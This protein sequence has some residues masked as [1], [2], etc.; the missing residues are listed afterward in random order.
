LSKTAAKASFNLLSEPWI[1]VVDLDGRPD[2]LALLD[3][4][5]NAKDFGGIAHED[6]LVVI[7]TYR[8][9]L[10]FLHRALDG[11]AETKET[12]DWFKNGFPAERIENYSSEWNSRFNLFDE[13]HP[14]GQH[15]RL[16]KEKWTDHWSRLMAAR[17]S[18]NTN[19]LYSYELRDRE[20]NVDVTSPQEALLQMLAHQHFALGGLTKRFITS[21]KSS[22]FA[23][24][25]LTLVM[26]KNLLETLCL[27]LIPY[28]ER[29]NQEQPHWEAGPAEIAA[30][31]RGAVKPV[32]GLTESY[33][34]AARSILFQPDESGGIA[35]M[36]YAE[37]L[38]PG[39]STYDDPMICLTLNRKGELY[40]LG[41]REERGLWRDLHSFVPGEGSTAPKVIAEAASVLRR[42]RRY[43]Q[44][45]D[46]ASFGI[47][48]NKAKI[49]QV[50]QE[51][52]RLPSLALDT[53]DLKTTLQ[54]WTQQAQEEAYQLAQALKVVA[55]GLLS[56][57][58]NGAAARDVKAQAAS[59]QA[60]SLYWPQAESLFWAHIDSL[61][62]AA[63]EYYQKAEEIEQAWQDH[64]KRL[65]VQVFNEVTNSLEPTPETLRAINKGY[66]ALW[67]GNS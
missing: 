23:T 4:I 22:P 17:G 39:D 5:R 12:V 26:G 46:F 48:N 44:P 20:D 3:L 36:T 59:F 14:F 58:R 28:G 32:Q 63:E 18:F 16:P 64:L 11:P 37:G 31:E 62:S 30:L 13:S 50:R 45:L 24:A 7:A 21:A 25:C 27:N 19:F 35:V 52:L 55:A 33:T 49:S 56:K 65:K 8:F 40:P 47:V 43:T 34:W 10:A 41:Y 61:P 2:E 6:P 29:H 38:S 60:D 53:P 54:S 42:A 51:T 66:R 57:R 67:K 9:V 15:P 1:P